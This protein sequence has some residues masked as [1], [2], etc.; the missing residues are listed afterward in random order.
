MIRDIQLFLSLA[1]MTMAVMPAS[2]AAGI[3]ITESH[4]KQA[5]AFLHPNISK[6][7]YHL[8]VWPNWLA[9]S[10]GFWHVTNTREGKRFFL[11]SFQDK[12]TEEAFCHQTLADI[13][14]ENLKIDADPDD[15]PFNRIDVLEGDTIAIELKDTVWHYHRET[16]ALFYHKERP[17]TDR[18]V[19]K[20][21]DDKFEAFIKDY[22]LFVRELESG[23][24]KQLSLTGKPLRCYGNPYGWSDIMEGPD[25]ERPEE[26]FVSWSPDSR[27]LFTVITDLRQAEKMYL[28]DQ[29]VDTLYRPRLLSYY[30]GSPGDTTIVYHKPVIFDLE[31]NKEVRV[32]V[33]PVPH[34]MSFGFNWN[35]EGDELYGL[36]THRGYKQADMLRINT[37]TGETRV[38]FSEYSNLSIESGKLIVERIGDD[39]LLFSSERNGWY[40]LYLYDYHSGELLTQITDGEFVVKSLVHVCEDSETIYFTAGGKEKSRNPYY[41]HLYKV[42]FDGLEVHLLSPENAHHQVRISPCGTYVVDNYSRIDQPTVSVMRELATGN[43]A[44][45]ISEADIDDLYEIGWSAPKQ[46]VVKGRDHETDIYGL[47]YYPVDFS[48]DDDYPLINYAYS[49]PHGSFIPKSFRQALINIMTPFTRFGFAVMM[50][51]GLGTSD[52]SRSFREWSYRNIGGNMHCHAAA[53]QQLAEQHSWLDVSRVGIFGHSAGGYDATRAMLLY[54][55]LFKVGVSSAANHDHRMEKAWWP[56]MYMGYPV[57]DYYHEQ[58]N[59]TNAENLEGRLLIAHGGIDENVNPSATFKLAGKLIEAGKDF[60]MLIMPGTRHGF[61]SSSGDYFT[62]VRWNY[63]IR[64]LLPA[65]P[66]HNYQFQTIAP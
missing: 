17:K 64:H 43:I 18:R 61:G 28:L 42:G 14:E 24:E 31:K 5:E 53:V 27:K 20:S 45:K 51:D 6:I 16:E 32:N 29:S 33:D 58:S 15:L 2:Y 65:E 11:T 8:D 54:P 9:D 39:F 35:E 3:E 10:S 55:D 49:G 40:H 59:I 60:D 66:I 23:E 38:L 22:N 21:P 19:V 48:P 41:D 63:F 37:E 13:I 34:F 62:K 25:G 12:S 26:I 7:V 47:L 52:R 1:L 57:G 44:Y 56:E 50:V 4:Y 30:R 36:Y 46:F